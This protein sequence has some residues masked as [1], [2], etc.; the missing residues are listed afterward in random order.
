MAPPPPHRFFCYRARSKSADSLY[1]LYMWYWGTGGKSAARILFILAEGCS[2][3]QEHP[4][5][6]THTHRQSFHPALLFS[7]LLSSCLSLLT[8]LLSGPVRSSLLKYPPTN[9]LLFFT[10]GN[11]D[12]Y[13]SLRLPVLS[14]LMFRSVFPLEINKERASQNLQLEVY[15]QTK[16]HTLNVKVYSFHFAYI[17]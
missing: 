16:F 14:H 2:G 1:V 15:L 7:F 6:P 9:K 17:S 11:Y 8:P 13:K 4:P 10:P 12:L 5:T 3:A